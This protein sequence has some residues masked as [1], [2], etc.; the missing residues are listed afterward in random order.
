M[1]KILLF[2][3]LFLS[4]SVEA[5]SPFAGNWEGKLNVGPGLRIIFHVTEDAAGN[6][7]T[8]M[9]SPDQGA[10]GLA[11]EKTEV[12]GDSLFLNIAVVGGKYAGKL[13]D[14]KTL[15]GE[16]HQGQHAMALNLVKTENT[17]AYNRPQTPKGPFSYKSEEV[18]YTNADN[19]I[20]YGATIT[21]PQGNGPFPAILLIT[22][23]GPQNR[24][25]EIFEHKPFAVLA[26]ALT[27]DGF[28]VLRVDDRGTGKTTGS[29]MT[30]T[31]EDF[32]QDARTSLQYLQNRKEVNTK[33]AGLLG[34]SEGGL[35]AEIIAASNKN[36]DFIVLTGAPGIPIPQ[37]MAEQ[38][39]QVLLKAGMSKELTTKYL[40]LYKDICHAVTTTSDREQAK[41]MIAETVK[42]WRSHTDS[43]TVMA[44]TGIHD[45][46]SEQKL[47]DR[48]TAEFT[49]P[50]TRQFLS[51]DPQSYIRKI[52]CK[53]LAIGGEKDIQVVSAGN[54]AGIKA[55]LEK[56]KSKSYEVKELPEL[57][58]LMQTCITCTIDEYKQLEETISPL[59]INTIK[60]WL[61]K[62]VK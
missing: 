51:Y 33:K 16:L 32:V 59:A 11:V 26:D 57:N 22:G 42:T 27:N 7:T 20:S 61:D 40:G 35:I 46:A 37:L 1:N 43:L 8:T 60:D 2:L 34:H 56:S 4:L 44:T 12:K 3:M 9:D 38:N 50:W 29:F 55:A 30:A 49:R 10:T 53:V 41:K 54:L 14:G 15:S 5:Q 58:H 19:S 24:D 6:Y 45:E 39:E 62:E 25:E 28:V 47:I 31:T 17:S 52:S 36:I 13:S 21:I 48:M 18:T 23:S